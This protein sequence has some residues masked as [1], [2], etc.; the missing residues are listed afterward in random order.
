MQQGIWCAFV[1]FSAYMIY[2][3]SSTGTRTAGTLYRAI[4]GPGLAGYVVLSVMQ[5]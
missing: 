2:R 1:Y 5:K 4:H 3:P